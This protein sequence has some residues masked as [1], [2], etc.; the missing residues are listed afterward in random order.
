M[1]KCMGECR[2]LQKKDCRDTCETW[3]TL[4]ELYRKWYEIANLSGI[5]TANIGI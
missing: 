1:Q 3:G 4:V 5:P 2:M